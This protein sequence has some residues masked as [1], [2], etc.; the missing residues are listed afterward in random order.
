MRN[1]LICP[2]LFA[3]MTLFV[4]ASVMA[5]GVP[6]APPEC[7]CDMFWSDFSTD[8]NVGT[9]TGSGTCSVVSLSPGTSSCQVQGTLTLCYSPNNF[10]ATSAFWRDPYTSFNPVTGTCTGTPSGNNQYTH[11][12][13]TVRDCNG[14]EIGSLVSI[15]GS[16][17]G[18]PH[19][20]VRGIRWHCNPQ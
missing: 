2:V 17:Y 5:Q 13:N 10:T 8:L 20:F 11:P 12:A 3:A 9:L 15:S 14:S 6:P 7:A 16:L 18:N 1:F 19:F 4:P